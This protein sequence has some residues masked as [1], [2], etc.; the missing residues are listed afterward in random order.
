MVGHPARCSHQVERATDGPRA[1]PV[2]Y[3]RRTLRSGTETSTCGGGGA[4]RSRIEEGGQGGGGTVFMAYGGEEGWAL[5]KF[6]STA[7]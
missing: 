5:S 2:G 6:G 3:L 1:E 7:A 4:L